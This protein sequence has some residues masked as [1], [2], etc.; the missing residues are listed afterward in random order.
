MIKDE[1]KKVEVS[2]D[3][4]PDILKGHYSNAV[5]VSVTDLEVI[6][7]FAF[8]FPNENNTGR[9]GIMT[10]R[11]VVSHNLATKLAS[12]ITKTLI[13]HVGKKKNDKKN[14]G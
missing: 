8:L 11:L 9:R 14:G 12:S 6:M 13:T 3:T 1:K 10:D 4:S 5:K 2:I 7:D